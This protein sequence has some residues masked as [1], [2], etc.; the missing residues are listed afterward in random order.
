MAKGL[1]IKLISV[2]N[3]VADQMVRHQGGKEE[4]STRPVWVT[5]EE[6]W[7]MRA[8]ISPM[9]KDGNG[10]N[11][12]IPLLVKV[13]E[14]ILSCDDTAR[15]GIENAQLGNKD[16]SHKQAKGTM[17]TTGHAAKPNKEP[18]EDDPGD[19][20]RRAGKKA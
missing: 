11:V 13:H 18:D 10:N 12:G 17:E 6:A 9:D 14:A 8:H 2:F 15:V 1:L 5:E 4:S 3:E 16:E 20:A 19:D 7:L